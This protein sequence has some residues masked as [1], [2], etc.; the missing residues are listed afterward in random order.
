MHASSYRHSLLYKNLI[1][2]FIKYICRFTVTNTIH[3][4]RVH[5]LLWVIICMLSVWLQL[6]QLKWGRSVKILVR[7]AYHCSSLKKKKK[8]RTCRPDRT[9]VIKESRNQ[10]TAASVSLTAVLSVCC[11]RCSLTLEYPCCEAPSY[12]WLI[13]DNRANLSILRHWFTKRTLILHIMI[14]MFLTMKYFYSYC[15]FFA[16]FVFFAP[17][18]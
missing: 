4:I 15:T 6:L 14:G 18:K 12:L 8:Q 17:G 9:A 3:Y 16:F 7:R 5:F 11:V 13:I 2:L 10:P 1:C